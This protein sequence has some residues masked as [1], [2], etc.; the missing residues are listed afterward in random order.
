MAPGGGRTRGSGSKD[1]PNGGEEK[2]MRQDIATV[3][4]MKWINDSIVNFVGK[5]AAVERT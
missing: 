1:K 2:V 5:D 3:R 4:P